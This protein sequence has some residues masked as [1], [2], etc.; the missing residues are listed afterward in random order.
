MG[1]AGERMAEAPF[2]R[3]GNFL[4]ASPANGRVRSDLSMRIAGEGLGD[5]ESR[6]QIADKEP[7]FDAADSSQRWRFAL[8]APEQIVDRARI[9]AGAHDN[10]LGVVQNLSAKAEIARKTPNG[11]AKPDTLHTATHPNFHRD[12]FHLRRVVLSDHSAASRWGTQLPPEAA[13]TGDAAMLNGMG[14]S[15]R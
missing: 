15:C 5:A 13:I 10:A 9:T 8:D 11:R 1:A 12:V 14:L 6:W 2:K 4:R 3:I 7:G